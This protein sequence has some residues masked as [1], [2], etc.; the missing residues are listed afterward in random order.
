MRLLFDHVA[1]FRPP[2]RINIEPKVSRWERRWTDLGNGHVE[3]QVERDDRP[4]KQNDE[5]GECRILKV[6][7]LDLH[8]PKL[9]SPA[10]RGVDWRRFES[11]SLPIG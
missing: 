8:T 4:R 7:H 5:Y 6:R 11:D 2:A 3:V 9:D 10:D 1:C